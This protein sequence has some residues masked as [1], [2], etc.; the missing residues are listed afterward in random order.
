MKYTIKNPIGD[1][2]GFGSVYLCTSEV[3]DKYA[4]KILRNLDAASIE[5]FKKE[6]RLTRRLAHP[7]IIKII[8]YDAEGDRKYY[9]MPLYTSSLKTVIPELYGKYDRQ[10]S[11]INEVLNGVIYLHSEGVL[12][13]DLKPQNILYNSDSDIVIND[14]GL[15]RQIDSGSDRLT[16]FG[17][18]FGTQ[19][20]TAPEQFINARNATEKS[21]VFSLGKIIED[22]VTNML[23]AA[24][25]TDDLRY[26]IDKCTQASPERRFSSAVELKTAIDSVYQHLLGI[27]ENSTM[28]NLLSK[29]KMGV[30]DNDAIQDLAIRLISCNNGDKL[31]EFFLHISNEQYKAFEKT[32]S[33]LAE[34]LSIRLQQYYTEQGWGFGYT[35]TIGNN[36]ERLYRL[37]NNIIVRAN[38]LY[39]IIEVG[40]SHNRWHVMRIA[41]NLLNVAIPNI[42]ECFELAKLL[43]A[44]QIYLDGISIEKTDLPTCLQPYFEQQ[45]IV[46]EES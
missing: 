39:A 34:T 7:N 26:I 28:D 14:F 46:S 5:R 31:E 9:I 16:R 3:G 19:R 30:A 27:A 33:S 32:N 24:I 13:R 21:D 6:I 12:H 2:G 23:S 25:P 22:M 8:A 10:Y 20:Y 40:I 41:A 35:D 1:P 36:C 17:D 42:A 11:I 44:G 29:L 37:S 4:I 45:D 43:S 18:G 15:G 38:L